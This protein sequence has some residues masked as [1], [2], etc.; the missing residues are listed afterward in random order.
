MRIVHSIAVALAAFIASAYLPAEADGPRMR[1]TTTTDPYAYTPPPE[2]LFYNWS[3]AYVGGHVAGAWSQDRATL[4]TGAAEPFAIRRVD[5]IGG[6]HGG[7]QH[8]FR[9]IVV[10]AEISYSWGGAELSFPS[11]ATPGLTVATRMNDLMLVSGRFGYAY[12]NWLAYT[13]AGWASAN[14]DFTASG[15]ATGTASGRGNGWVA[16]IGISYAFGP[17]LI[18]GVEYDYVRLNASGVDLVPGTATL[19]GTGLDVQNAMLR[20]E[21]K[22]GR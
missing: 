2:Q 16:G 20:L 13:K 5:A 4:T 8:Q 21:Y 1:G 10:G 3:G 9:E 22:F 6:V 12:M 19:S 15:A 17:N 11:A 7:Y 14:L 18:A